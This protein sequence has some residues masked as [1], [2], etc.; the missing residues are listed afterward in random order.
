M[1]TDNFIKLLHFSPEDINNNPGCPTAY[2]DKGQFY[3]FF[4]FYHEN[5]NNNLAYQYERARENG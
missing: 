2:L 3:S 5:T 4:S 1:K